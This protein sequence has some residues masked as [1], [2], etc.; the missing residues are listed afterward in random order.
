MK[1]AVS[2]QK[3]RNKRHI[4]DKQKDNLYYLRT[5]LT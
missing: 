2:G 1:P 5:N 4:E 3:E